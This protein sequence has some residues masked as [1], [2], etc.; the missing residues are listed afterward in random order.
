MPCTPTNSLIVFPCD[1]PIKIMGA[2]DENFAQ[3]VGEVVRRH[4]P[5]FDKEAIE[6]RS[7]SKGNYL[8]LTVTVRATSQEQLDKLYIALSSHPMVKIVI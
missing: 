7:S 1:F 2:T 6:I 5:F 4:D 8:G 3:T